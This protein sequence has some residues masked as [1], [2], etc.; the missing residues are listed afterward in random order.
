MPSCKLHSRISVAAQKT[1]GAIAKTTRTSLNV[2]AIRF[3]EDLRAPAERNG[4]RWNAMV[5]DRP[6]RR[7]V[8]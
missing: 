3:A 2:N 4:G 8:A 7:V 6:S 5:V 1:T